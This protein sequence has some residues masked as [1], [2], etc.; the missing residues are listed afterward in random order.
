MSVGV[1][2]IDSDVIAQKRNAAIKGAF[3]TEFVDMFDIYL[4]TIILTPA[5]A[6]FQPTQLPQ[7]LAG[8]LTSLVFITTLLGRPIGA[9]IFGAIGDKIGRRKATIGSVA[10]FGLITLLIALLP[11]YHS[12]GIT[13]Y[14][15]LVILRF[16]DGV[17]LGGG[18]T[19][20]HPLAMEYSEKHKRGF[21][22]A[23]I[24]AAFPLAYILI[25]L[26]GMVEFSLVPQAGP[27]SAY[28]IWGWRIPFVIGAL[29][30]GWLTLY[31]I[32]K[33]PES[34]TWEK[35]KKEKTSLLRMFKGKAGKSFIQVLVMMIGFWLT[36]N[37]VTLV[38]PTTVLRDILGLG[39][40]QVTLTL[41]ISYVVLFGSYIVSGVISQ[42]IGRR[43][44]FLILGP[45]IAIVGAG[46]LYILINGKSLPLAL[47]ILIVCVF[48]AIVTAPWG[49]IVTYINERFATEVR[50]SGFGLG[51][52]ASVIIPSF[53]A[54]YMNWLG[55][56]MP[57]ETTIIALL[58]IG[59]I[60]G[61]IGAYFGP[62]TKDVDFTHVE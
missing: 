8:I 52:S 23:L 15:L 55:V 38:L 11:G 41:L 26:I 62:E 14:V 58:I 17:C 49:A 50:A 44:F 51:F 9:T 30:A 42:K 59:G 18:Y 16:L 5:L 2:S 1:R 34:E 29:I 54:F 20:S 39:S 31:Y 60:I 57:Y 10:G 48:S 46:L 47:I 27:A 19:G 3:F 53:Y 43:T 56:F 12:I 25:N 32:R 45:S 24:L 33:V 4:P 28:A 7:G 22:G 40:F 6:Y 35:S 36:Q 61:A 13:S 37:I 21:V